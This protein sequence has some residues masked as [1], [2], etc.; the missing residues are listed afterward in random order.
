MKPIIRH[1]YNCKYCDSA[2]EYTTFL[3]QDIKTCKVYYNRIET[4]RLR[5]L[6]CKFY[7]A[8]PLESEDENNEKA[9]D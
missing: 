4:P 7:S 5:A 1:C 9:A 2:I 3:I 6:F 8:N